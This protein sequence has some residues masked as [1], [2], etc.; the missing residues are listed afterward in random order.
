M[1]APCACPSRRARWPQS[2]GWP[3]R[4]S[5]FVDRWLPYAERAGALLAATAAVYLH[6]ASLESAYAAVRSRFLDHLSAGLP[7]VVSGGDAAAALVEQHRLGRVVA[8]GDVCGHRRALLALLGDKAERSGCAERAC[9]LASEYRWERVAEPLLEFCCDP[10]MTTDDRRPTTDDRTGRSIETPQPRRSI[11]GH[12]RHRRARP[13]RTR[14]GYAA[15]RGAT[16]AGREPPGGRAPAPRRPAG[17]IRR[18]LVEHVVRPFVAPL[19]EQQNAH[20]AAVLRALDALAENADANRSEIFALLSASCVNGFTSEWPR[21]LRLDEP[22][23]R[24]GRRRPARRAIGSTRTWPTWTTPTRCI[25]RTYR[26]PRS[27]QKAAMIVLSWNG[28]DGV[29][30][31]SMRC[32]PSRTPRPSCWWWTTARVDGSAALVRERYPQVQLV[33][34]G[35]NLGFSAGMNGRHAAA[36]QLPRP[37]D[38]IVLLNQDTVVGPA[39]LRAILAPFDPGATSRSARSA[40]RSTTPMGERS[41][42]RGPGSSLD[43]RSRGTMAVAS[44]TRAQTRPAAR[45]SSM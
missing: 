13:A 41:S 39:W 26:R 36:A 25:S 42:T 21:R 24:P 4:R 3:S 37:P 2:W 8:P 10:Q 22:R 43:A 27:N 29:P 6:E 12:P 15:Q 32:W 16:G 9:A 40:A 44:S 23:D 34:N 28:A 35:R 33:E 11:R 45:R 30:A 18:L 19:V 20:N 38:V 5:A 14:A 1:P 7:S 17:R 31:C